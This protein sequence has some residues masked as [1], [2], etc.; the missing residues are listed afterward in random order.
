M[1][2]NYKVCRSYEDILSLSLS[3]LTDVGY[4]RCNKELPERIERSTENSLALEGGDRRHMR[5]TTHRYTMVRIE[6]FLEARSAI[7]CHVLA[8]LG[9]YAST[10]A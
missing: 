6:G 5:A 2:T 9:K 10:N 7:M 4:R 1:R 3:R 8:L